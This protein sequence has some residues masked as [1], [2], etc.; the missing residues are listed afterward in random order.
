MAIINKLLFGSQRVKSAMV[1]ATNTPTLMRKTTEKPRITVETFNWPELSETF[2]FIAI[3]GADFKPVIDRGLN[4]ANEIRDF[5]V[6]VP[7]MTTAIVI[8]SSNGRTRMIINEGP[9]AET[10]PMY[11]AGFA[12]TQWW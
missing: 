5:S 10:Y 2:Y 9:G 8:T 11:G 7:E 6:F 3:D 12:G 1:E 4:P